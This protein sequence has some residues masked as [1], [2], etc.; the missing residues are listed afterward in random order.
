MNKALEKFEKAKLMDKINE[1]LPSK[2]V[3]TSTVNS[4]EKKK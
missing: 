2:T 3:T 4:N 1:K